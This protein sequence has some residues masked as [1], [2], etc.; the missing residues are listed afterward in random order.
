MRCREII[1]LLEQ[2]GWKQISQTGSHLKLKKKN[3][4]VVVPVHKRRYS[5]W[6]S[7]KHQENGRA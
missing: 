5:N 4:I 6:N 7:K 3:K 1:K 2:N